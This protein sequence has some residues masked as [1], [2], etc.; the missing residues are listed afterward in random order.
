MPH[1]FPAYT[2]AAICAC[3]PNGDTAGADAQTAA[4]ASV[5]VEALTHA[6]VF[7]TEA[8]GAIVRGDLI[9]VHACSD[10][11]CEPVPWSTTG[12]TARPE[13][14]GDT[15]RFAWAIAPQ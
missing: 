13:I 14:A 2:L 12:T 9:S 4:P 15:Y 6:E 5:I 10:G 11:I 7:D 3:A 1:R 8:G